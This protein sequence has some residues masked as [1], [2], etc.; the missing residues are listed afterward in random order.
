MMGL[1]DY[2]SDSG[3]DNDD[4]PNGAVEN[5]TQ[6]MVPKAKSE[7]S[8]VNGRDNSYFNEDDVFEGTSSLNL[9][10]VIEPTNAVAETKAEDELEDMVKPKDWEVKLAEKELKRREKKARKREK[11]EKLRKERRMLE[12]ASSGQEKSIKGKAKIAAF[13]ALKAI[14]GESDSDSEDE[15]VDKSPM[16][17][18]KPKGSNLL[19]MLPTPKSGKSTTGLGGAN[20]KGAGIMLPPSLRNKTTTPGTTSKVSSAKAAAAKRSAT[21]D[22]SDDDSLPTDF[23]GLS[24][25]P[26]PKIPRVGD[27]PALINGVADVVGPSRPTKLD[28]DVDE[29]YGYPEVGPS[30]SEPATEGVIT[31]E[32]AHRLIMKYEVGPAGPMEHRSLNSIAGDIVDIR[33]DDALGPDVRATLLKNLHV[34]ARAKDAMAPLPKSKNPAD[35]TSKRKH[36]ITYLANLAVAREEALQQQWAE[37]KQMRRMGRQKYGF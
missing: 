13:G 17:A 7:Q 12:A 22:D 34:A 25:A 4:T 32:E 15:K 18:S 23:F 21:S 8:A 37:S 16:P 33:V 26:E 31:D 9:P 36:Q 1:V 14:A 6:P 20:S 29:S 2:G 35:V 24:S 19:S 5:V 3:S 30:S 27:V 10:S 11:K 28:V